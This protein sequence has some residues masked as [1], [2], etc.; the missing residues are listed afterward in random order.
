M[1]C[2][3]CGN[4][5]EDG[6]KFCPKCGTPT[7][8]GAQPQQ[9][10]QEPQLEQPQ[11]T[12]QEPQLE[13]PQ[14]AY[15]QAPQM[16]AQ[17]TYEQPAQQMQEQQVYDQQAYGQASQYDQSQQMYGQA[18][19]MQ[20]QQAYGQAPQ[21]MY[22][23][24]PV[25]APKKK[26]KAPLII[27]LVVL[28]VVLIGGG[29]GF[30][31]YWVN[32]PIN[33]VNKAMEAGNYVEAANYYIDLTD[34]A[35]K[36]EVQKQ[37]LSVL[38]GNFDAYVAGTM[39]YDTAIDTFNTVE[40]AMFSDN[41][42]YD[43]VRT[44]LNSLKASR[45]AWDD[46]NEAFAAE[47]YEY[48]MALYEQVIS[49]DSNYNA[50]QSKIAECE[51]LMVPDVV[52]EWG[53]T[54]DIGK[55]FAEEEIGDSSNVNLTL[56]MTMVYKFNEDGTGEAFVD[57]D[58]LIPALRDFYEAI[59]DYIVEE[60]LAGTGLSYSDMD[61]LCKE[62]YGMSFKDYYMASFDPEDFIEE[63]EEIEETFTYIVEKKEITVTFDGAYSN[64]CFEYEDGELLL[65]SSGDDID[66]LS[67]FDLSLPLTFEKR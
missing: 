1:I 27:T 29:V 40:Y 24:A 66:F 13:Q 51:E 42:E 31:I 48:A 49:S 28:L 54:V 52:G 50:A 61:E 33:K 53:V 3:T 43:E 26:S 37:M 8:V 35:Q 7:G 14:Q 10:V 56:P 30:G 6:V 38:K 59:F 34:E 15:E 46:A 44:K 11:Q 39:D 9:T 41:A 57:T 18:P 17:Q 36:A 4:Q 47:D 65:V 55:R 45:D 25:A 22:N 16:Q 63:F 5:I 21:Q 62:F 58:A 12:V 23:Q 67:E 19:Q 60:E 32:R 20:P 2:N 64:D